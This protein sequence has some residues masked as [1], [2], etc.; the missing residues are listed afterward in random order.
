M[1]FG[2]YEEE[3]NYDYIIRELKLYHITSI[4]S[5]KI[6]AIDIFYTSLF[7]DVKQ[8]IRKI[9]K[10]NSCRISHGGYESCSL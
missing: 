8:Y 2:G 6:E 5:K 10:W 7:S 9:R 1:G 3:V 4:G